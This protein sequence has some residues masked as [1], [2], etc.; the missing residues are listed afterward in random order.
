MPSSEKQIIASRKNALL[1]GRPP[2]KVTLVRRME[3]RQKEV[4]DKMV[5]NKT[6][7]LMRAGF[8][9]ALGQIFCYKLEIINGQ[10]KH[11]LIED[12]KEI[13][14]ALDLISNNGVSEDGRFYYVTT[15][16][17]DA[18]AIEM[19]LNRAYG[20]PKESLTIDGEVQF[21]L[22]ALAQ[23][24]K[25]LEVESKDVTDVGAHVL[26]VSAVDVDKQNEE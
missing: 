24:R 18:K 3:L 9:V 8:S 11:T 20:K 6:K 1:G 21:S 19:L 7:W 16:E 22:K 5:Y 23:H 13:E 2:G 10:K 17:P 14:K 26:D 12:P 4:M 25:S 15:K